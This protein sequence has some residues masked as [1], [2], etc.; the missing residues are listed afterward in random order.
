MPCY[1][2][3]RGWYSST[4]NPTGKRSIV[5]N[6][7]EGNGDEVDLACGQCIGC[8]LERSKQW[9][10]RIL[11]EASLYENN[12]F[13]TLT[14]DEKNMP[15]DGSLNLRHYQLFM[16]KLRKRFGNGIRFFHCGEYGEHTERPHYHACIFN[17]DF[18]DKYKWRNTNQGHSI[19]R[20]EI[21]D[22]ISR[23]ETERN[24]INKNAL[25]PYGNSEI[26]DVTFESAAY[27]ARYITK[28]ILGKDSDLAYL[29]PE[30]RSNGLIKQKEYVTMSRRPGIGK[31][32]LE[33]FNTDVYPHDYVVI[34]GKKM[35]PPKYYDSQMGLDDPSL[36]EDLK[37]RRI[38]NGKKLAHDN[39]IHRR[40]VKEIVH[41]AQAKF[42]KRSYENET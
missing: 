29:H 13:L 14:Y 42:L 38:E 39:N 12:C 5:F 28:K 15:K 37:E 24:D 30:W 10:I 9:A 11:H 36:L 19:Y 33:K 27:V 4:Q 1:N 18:P 6:H 31:G 26:G 34:R 35:R 20:S 25:W 32:W 2:P 40:H 7:R 22:G 23:G 16:K 3:L 21:L 41:E 8:R 17:F